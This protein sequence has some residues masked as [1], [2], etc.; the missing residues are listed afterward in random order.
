MMFARRLSIQLKPNKFNEF[1]KTFEKDI[2]PLLRKQQG[3]KDEITFAAPDGI[4][5]LAISL[6]DTEKNAQSY[7]GSAYKDVLNLLGSVIAETPKV[8]TSEV[9]HST[10]HQIHAGVLVA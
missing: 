9:I 6:W 8:V 5:L 7:D 10:F 2:I 3:F 1:T 4:K